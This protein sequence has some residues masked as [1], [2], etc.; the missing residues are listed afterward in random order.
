MYLGKRDFIDHCDG[1]VDPVEGVISVEKDYLK[2]RKIY[3]QVSSVH[4]IMFSA[5]FL[6]QS[7]GRHFKFSGKYQCLH[8]SMEENPLKSSGEFPMLYYPHQFFVPYQE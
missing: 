4:F 6:K 5:R 3:G 1:N 7:F 2:G 8:S